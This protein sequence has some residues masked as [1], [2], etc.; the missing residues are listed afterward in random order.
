MLARF[1]ISFVSSCSFVFGPRVD[2]NH[3]LAQRGATTLA[4]MALI[5][6]TFSIKGLFVILSIYDNMTLVVNNTLRNK[7]LLL[8]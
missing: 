6:M 7:I 2:S 8:C 3:S 4:I 5:I 1:N